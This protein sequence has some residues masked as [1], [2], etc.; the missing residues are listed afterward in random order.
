M[1]RVAS[2]ASAMAA[3]VAGCGDLSDEPDDSRCPD[4]VTESLVTVTVGASRYRIGEPSAMVRGTADHTLGLAVRRITVARIDATSESFNV[5]AWVAT[6]PGAVIEGR[7]AAGG[8]L[9]ADVEV[10]VMAYEPCAGATPM[11]VGT[12]TVRVEAAPVDAGVTN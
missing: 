5:A 6:I 7:V 8:M 4:L 2:I 1:S 11:E 10:P 12:A 9:P 3:L